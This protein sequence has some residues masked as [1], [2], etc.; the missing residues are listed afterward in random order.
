M[1]DEK[2]EYSLYL[3]KGYGGIIYKNTIKDSLKGIRAILTVLARGF[4]EDCRDERIESIERKHRYTVAFL[5]IWLLGDGISL[6]K[7]N[8]PQNDLSEIEK[9]PLLK[10]RCELAK[11]ACLLSYMEEK[12][13]KTGSKSNADYLRS[14]IKQWDSPVFPSQDKENEKKRPESSKSTLN[15]IRFK[16]I[17][18]DA[19]EQGPLKKN[20]MLIR[21]SSEWGYGISGLD[22]RSYVDRESRMR[23]LLGIVAIYLLNKPQ[24]CKS[25]NVTIAQ[26]SNYLGKPCNEGLESIYKS[27][28][29]FIDYGGFAYNNTPLFVKEELANSCTKLTVNAEWLQRFDVHLASADL[30][31]ESGYVVYDDEKLC[32]ALNKNK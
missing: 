16:C 27:V 21:Y 14:R 26:I 28:A 6:L 19:L 25:A 20:V 5:K 30:S 3:T 8:D 12:G 10:E 2:L 13:I 29:T 31:K 17:V 7:D 23:T 4:L 32:G 9:Y 11:N 15:A 1:L 18:A 24:N 22:A